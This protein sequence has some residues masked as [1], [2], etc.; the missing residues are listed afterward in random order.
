MKHLTCK[1]LLVACMLGASVPRL[2]AEPANP[3][4]YANETPAQRDARMQWWREARFGM[5]IHWGLYAIPAGEWNG[6]RAKGYAEWIMSKARIPKEEYGKLQAQFNPTRYDPAAWVA[7]AKSAGMKYIVITSKHHDGFCLFESEHTDYDMSG[8]AYRRDLLKPLADECHRQGIKICWYHSIM[9]WHHPLAGGKNF[10][11]YVKHM[12]SQC[13]ELL[14]NYGDI[15]VMWFDGE[16]IKD[17]TAPQGVELEKFLRGIQ[18][19]LIVNNRVGKRGRSPG[20]F[21]TPEQRIPA[22]GLGDSD[23]ETCMTINGSWGYSKFDNGWKSVE[24]LIRNLIDIASKGGNFLLNVGPTAEGEIPQPSVERLQEMGKWL[25]V[26]GE[27]IYGTK[28]SPFAKLPFDGRCTLLRQG[29]GGQA[30]LRPGAG[31]QAAQTAK[32]FLHVF[33]RP[34]DGKITLPMS[35]TITKAYL[36][37]TPDTSLKVDDKTIVLPDSLPDPIATVVAVEIAGALEVVKESTPATGAK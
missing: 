26:N 23:W 33:R 14:T 9:D 25:K 34:A 20:D 16:W 37:A 19:N 7:L 35:N 6:Q 13:R 11:D 1:I 36:L 15:G 31:G 22:T 32:L 28:A 8:T 3:D 5:F 24:S 10:P 21:G 29:F 30:L 18:P 12:K 2:A 27:A 4:P 17:W